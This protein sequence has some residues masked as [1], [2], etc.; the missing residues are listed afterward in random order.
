MRSVGGVS[1]PCLLLSSRSAYVAQVRSRRGRASAGPVCCC[2]AGLQVW[3]R[4][5]GTAAVSALIYLLT[6]LPPHTHHPFAHLPCLACPNAPGPL[7]SDARRTIERDLGLGR[8]SACM[9]GRPHTPA[10]TDDRQVLIR[11]D[12]LADNCARHMRAMPTLV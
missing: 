3:R 7:S 4:S 1:R 2:P 11:H 12:W 8:E 5:G 6:P 10:V 9:L